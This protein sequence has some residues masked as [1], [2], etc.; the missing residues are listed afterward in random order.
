MKHLSQYFTEKLNVQAPVLESGASG[1]MMHPYDVDEFT[2]YD[3]EELIRTVFGGRMEGMTEKMDGF[4]IQASMNRNG[5]VV[6]IRNKG[7][8]NSEKGGMTID[9]FPSHWDDNPH[10]LENYTK[11]AKIIEAVFKKVGKEWFNPSDTTR[12]V[13]N[14][15]CILEGV[16]NTIPYA[17]DQVDFHNIWIYEKQESDSEWKNTEVTKR[18]LD[19][20]EKA[21]EGIDNAKITP[22]VIIKYSEETERLEKKWLGEWS[23]FLKTYDCSPDTTIEGIKF[24]LF[25]KWIEKNASWLMDDYKAAQ[26][27]CRRWVFR[28]KNS[29]NLRD[30]KDIYKDHL[31]EFVTLDKRANKVCGDVLLPLQKFFYGLGADIIRVTSGFVND[32]QDGTIKSLLKDLQTATDK[33]KREGSLEDNEFLQKWLD[34]LND[35]GQENLASAEGIVFSYKGKMMK[36]T[37]G[38]VPLNRIIGYSKYTMKPKSLVESLFDN[39]LVEKVLPEHEIALSIIK[40]CLNKTKTKYDIIDKSVEDTYIE[41]KF[42]KPQSPAEIHSWS[43]DIKEKLLKNKISCLSVGNDS[44]TMIIRFH[45]SLDESLNESLFD[46]NIRKKTVPE[47]L[48]YVLKKFFGKDVALCEDHQGSLKWYEVNPSTMQ[49][50]PSISLNARIINYFKKVDGLEIKQDILPTF[51][52]TKGYK[53]GDDDY[54]VYISMVKY[55]E[56][57]IKVSKEF[58]DS[59]ALPHDQKGVVERG[60][61]E[62]QRW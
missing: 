36:W 48:A 59:M 61:K 27:V 47:K 53:I 30:L 28:D 11:G 7:N 52:T 15:E 39:G 21:C 33:I 1:H 16:T 22:Q 55:G 5:D 23:K 37:G 38:F 20:I 10:A 2:G 3:I 41:I 57:K 42:D 62:W 9:D 51:E 34:V 31:D 56:R 19:V 12:R 13:V 17:S 29:A 49:V 43:T 4:G 54:W 35:I 45:W 46:D 50:T 25:F 58:Y 6:F 44:K 14:C 40:D 8:L 24:S 32:G 60:W 18:G 26:D